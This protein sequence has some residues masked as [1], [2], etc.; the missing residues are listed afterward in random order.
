ME[1]V[2]YNN[3]N[4]QNRYN[5]PVAKVR[6]LKNTSKMPYKKCR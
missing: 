1:I 3:G 2:I 6:Q 5:L 4:V